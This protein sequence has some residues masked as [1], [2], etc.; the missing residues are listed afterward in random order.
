MK[1]KHMG[2]L[3]GLILVLSFLAGCGA[4]QNA[5]PTTDP[6]VIY[7]QVAEQAAQTAA[8]QQTNI[9]KLTP[10]ATSTPQP[11]DMPEASPTVGTPN[12]TSAGTQT[13]PGAQSTTNPNAAGTPGGTSPTTVVLPTNTK[14]AASLPDKML[15]VS[16]SP[17]DGSVFK[18]GDTFT[19]TWKIQNVGTTTWS[20][21]YRVR[22]YGGERFGVADFNLGSTIAPEATVNITAQMTAPSSTGAYNSIWVPTNLDGANF[23]YFTFNCEV[24]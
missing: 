10:Q 2:A 23:G 3:A 18:P 22:L 9:A 17:A 1:I 5:T 4:G 7:T 16:Q 24:K 19:M 21:N 13:T 20:D 6:K 14:P 15:Y 12:P 11:T 8:A